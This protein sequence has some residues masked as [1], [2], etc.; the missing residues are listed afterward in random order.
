MDKCNK[1]MNNQNHLIKK[2]KK[3]KFHHKLFKLKIKLMKIKNKN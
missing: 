2:N 3:Y 1:L